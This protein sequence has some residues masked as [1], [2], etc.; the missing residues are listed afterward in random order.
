[1][2]VNVW[3]V[4]QTGVAAAL[5]WL[6]ATDLFHHQQAFFAPIAAV[7]TLAVSV[8]QRLR[9]AVELVLGVALGIAVGDLLIYWIGTGAWQIGLAVILAI[10]AAIFLGGGAPLVTQ[11]ASSA[12]LVATLAP[13][14]TGVYYTRFLD[15]LIGGVLGLLVMALLLPLNPLTVVVRAANPKLDVLAGG[16]A[17]T[18]V[19]LREGAQDRAQAALDR[20]RGAEAELRRLTDAIAAGRE[21]VTLAPVR[22]RARAPLAQYVDAAEHLARALRNSRVL[23]RRAVTLIKDDE[24]VPGP[25]AQ[26][27]ADLAEAVRRLRRELADGAEPVGARER[28]LRA[29]DAA[30]RAYADGVGFS[31]SVIVAQVR[32]T[33]TDLLRASGLAPKQS[34]QLVRKTFKRAAAAS[35]RSEG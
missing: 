35:A 15:A 13:P 8:G 31:G 19:A 18:A 30:A 7:V 2:R 25:L 4:G 1:V 23:V 16:L 29:V 27:V 14:S 10:V 12:V 22:W 20:L 28:A 34:D 33:A 21:T 24:R 17:E 11:A 5:A 9:R 6:V 3:L 26:A 32:S